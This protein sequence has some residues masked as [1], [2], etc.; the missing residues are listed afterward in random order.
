M[1]GRPRLELKSPDDLV[2]MHRAGQVVA[3]TL[4]VVR[5]LL[6]P[7]IS[8]RE[9]DAAAERHIRDL[10][11]TPSFLGYHGFVGSICVSVNDEVVHGVPGDRV[12]R[13]GDLVSVDCGAILDG[14]HG[15][16]AFTAPL[17]EVPADVAALDRATEAAL[18]AGIAA[19][20]LGGR[21]SDI[22][23]AVETSVRS[24]GPFGVVEEYTGHGIGTEMHLPPDVPNVGRPGRG[25]RIVP[26]LALA[27]EPMVTLGAATTDVL[28]DEWT[29]VTTDGSWAAH[30]EHSVTWTTDGPWVLTALDG[31]RERLGAL[32]VPC[33]AP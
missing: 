1:L 31:G 16:A 22:S 5:D 13:D 23:H 2:G 15:D 14:W 28:D 20:A 19:G 3:R 4:D 24:A 9:L 11:A 29:A 26:G 21:L 17:G 32:G 25:P 30:H 12:L 10:G 27:I 18:W 33:G 6:R 7:G 8:T